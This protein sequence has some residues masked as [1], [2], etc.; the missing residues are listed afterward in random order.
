MSFI[1]IERRQLAFDTAANWT[2]Q[3]PILATG[4]LGYE[5]GTNR[6]KIGDGAT[7]WN[8]LNAA[9]LALGNISA[10]GL[11]VGTTV[12]STGS[13]LEVAGSISATGKIYVG[14]TSVYID[15]SSGNLAFGQGSA[16]KM[17]LSTTGLSVTGEVQATTLRI[18]TAPSASAAT[19]STHKV[20]VNLNGTT[21][22]LLATT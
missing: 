10:T 11:L 14:A 2:A 22:Y 21:Y 12:V 19:P 7:A 20:A 5:T 1:K 16:D 17:L 6:L 3:N 15:Y 18:N 4:E 13:K 9:P 8:S